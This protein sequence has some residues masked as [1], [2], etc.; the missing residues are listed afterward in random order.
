MHSSTRARLSVLSQH[1]MASSTW[2][3][4]KAK[5]PF[6]IERVNIATAS[7][8]FESGH[9]FDVSGQFDSIHHA[10]LSTM[11]LPWHQGEE[12]KVDVCNSFLF[13]VAVDHPC[14][15]TQ[16]ASS[17]RYHFEE[18]KTV[19]LSL[20]PTFLLIWCHFLC[21][22]LPSFVH[23][24]PRVLFNLLPSP[25]LLMH[26]FK[27]VARN[28]RGRKKP[29]TFSSHLCSPLSCGTFT[30]NVRVGGECVF[31]LAVADWGLLSL[32]CRCDL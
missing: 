20:I 29:T 23:L 14:I 17:Q 28:L 1:R 25:S 3:E 11:N 24:G 6:I 18:I 31:G 8:V 7:L 32:C 22:S 2:A 27:T 30:A 9:M 13:Q 19:D 12:Q 16:T 21:L 26:D 10:S 4:I 15:Q 5:R